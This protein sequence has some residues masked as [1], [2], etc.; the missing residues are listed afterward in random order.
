MSNSNESIKKVQNESTQ[1]QE[2]LKLE[3][4][5]SSPLIIQEQPVSNMI[6]SQSK[7]NRNQ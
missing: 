1:Q 4:F 5:T 6:I 2:S 3:K 7:K